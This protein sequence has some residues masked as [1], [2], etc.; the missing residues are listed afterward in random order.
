MDLVL[1]S[2]SHFQLGHV[3]LLLLIFGLSQISCLLGSP[4]FNP[5]N[6]DVQ[7]GSFSCFRGLLF[8]GTQLFGLFLFLSFLARKKKCYCVSMHAYCME[9]NLF[10]LDFLEGQKKEIE[11]NCH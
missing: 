9:W 3:L 8:R 11:V 2:D 1:P 7:I 5:S 4:C 10:N 6:Q